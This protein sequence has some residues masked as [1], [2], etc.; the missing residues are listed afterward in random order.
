MMRYWDCG[1]GFS[2]MDGFGGIF[3]I[4]FWIIIVVL[5]IALMRRMLWLGGGMSRRRDM[6]YGGH[7]GGGKDSI[8]ILKERYAKGEI[9]KTEFDEKKKDLEAG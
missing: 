8:D 2:G 1:Y 7:M 3:M 4:F 6:F 9:N 5:F